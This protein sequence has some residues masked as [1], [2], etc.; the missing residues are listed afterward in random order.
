[1]TTHLQ[2]L[3]DSG[4]TQSKQWILYAV[5][6]GLIAFLVILAFVLEKIL[7]RAKH[8]EKHN[9]TEETRLKDD[10]DDDDLITDEDNRESIGEDGV[11]N[12]DYKVKLIEAED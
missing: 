10:N 3:M 5:L 9:E 11:K 6:G 1:M 7:S 4:D 8:H 2:G 12:K